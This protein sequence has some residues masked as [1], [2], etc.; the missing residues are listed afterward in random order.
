VFESSGNLEGAPP[1]RA[2][3]SAEAFRDLVGRYAEI[4]MSELV[5]YFPETS[6][7]RRVMEEVA[8]LLPALR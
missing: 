7:H 1:T 4:G 3:S 5:F 2:F 6:E 8:G